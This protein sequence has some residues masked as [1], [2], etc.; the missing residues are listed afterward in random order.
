MLSVILIGPEDS[1]VRDW[2]TKLADMIGITVSHHAA[3]YP[4]AGELR[5]MLDQFEPDAVIINLADYTQ[6]CRSVGRLNMERP[7]LPLIALHTAAEPQLLLDLMQLG[8]REL[9]FPPLDAGHMQN[10]VNRLLQQKQAA[11]SDKTSAGSVIAFLPARG[12]C[13]ST[14][15]ALNTAGAIGRLGKSALL[16]DFDFHNSIVAFWLK[17]DP[18]HGMNEALDRAHWLDDAL[19]KNIVQPVGGIDVLTAPQAASPVFSAVETAALLDF[20][21]QTYEFV[22]IDL[23]DAIYTSCWEVLDHARWILLVVTPEMASLYLARRK[24]AQMVDHGVPR[25]NIRLLL[26]RVSQFD[27]QP[28]EVEKF[29][30][31]PVAAT[32]ANQYRAITTAFTDGKPVPADSKL[33]LQYGRLAQILAGIPQAAEKKPAPG[34]LRQIFSSA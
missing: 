26:N 14:T 20:A 32:F 1:V 4:S 30:S 6:V 18:R 29:L 16:A 22:L 11:A 10:A 25:D 9:W 13:G 34:K 28:S 27:L 7:H 3:R 33:G 31:L 5:A 15:I 24:I 17:L 21:R 8:V 19:W 12:G 2:K 23:P